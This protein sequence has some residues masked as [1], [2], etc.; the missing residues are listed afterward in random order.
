MKQVR[1]IYNSPPEMRREG[2]KKTYANL[3][4]ALCD[5]L[6]M[7]ALKFDEVARVLKNDA[8]IEGFIVDARVKARVLGRDVQRLE[9]KRASATR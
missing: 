5:L 7:N 9:G 2:R 3:E 8:A 6:E 1:L 4:M